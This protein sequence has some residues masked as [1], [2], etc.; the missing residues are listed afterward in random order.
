MESEHGVLRRAL[1]RL[2]DSSGG[3]EIRRGNGQD[4]DDDGEIWR[5]VGRSGRR[6]EGRTGSGSFEGAREET[7]ISRY[8]RA[9]S[10]RE[11]G[12]ASKCTGPRF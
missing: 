5:G 7:D 10:S 6:G 1:Q 11:R 12:P 2:G 3:G 4:L 8:R 9:P